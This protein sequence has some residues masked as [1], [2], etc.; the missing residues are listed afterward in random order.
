[1][2]MIMGEAKAAEPA[3]EKIPA[4]EVSE[5]VPEAGETDIASQIEQ[6]IAEDE[7]ATVELHKEAVPPQEPGSIPAADEDTGE[8]EPGKPAPEDNTEEPVDNEIQAIVIEAKEMHLLC[9]IVIRMGART[10]RLFDDRVEADEFENDEDDI[11]IDLLKRMYRAGE[12]FEALELLEMIFLMINAYEPV[13]L[14]DIIQSMGDAECCRLF[15][16][17]FINESSRTD[18]E[19][20]RKS[21]GRHDEETNEVKKDD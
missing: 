2:G 3:E 1:M 16:T 5:N 19:I 10:S 7:E 21:I 11:V 20:L 18:L 13:E 4:A 17:G 8:E 12:Y 15:L 6:K 14:L 9:P